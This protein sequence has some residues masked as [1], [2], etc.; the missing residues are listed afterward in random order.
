MMK[1]KALATLLLV[2]LLGAPLARAVADRV[3]D[4]TDRNSNELGGEVAANVGANYEPGVI[5][6]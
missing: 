5:I 3:H 2:N 4:F 6:V 1:T